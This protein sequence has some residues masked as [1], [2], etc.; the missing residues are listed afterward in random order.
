MSISLTYR[1]PAFGRAWEEEKAEAFALSAAGEIEII[2]ADG[3]REAGGGLSPAGEWWVAA[4]RRTEPRFFEN[5]G[6][7]FEL[8]LGPAAVPVIQGALIGSGVGD[9]L[10]LSETFDDRLLAIASDGYWH[11]PD[12]VMA[13]EIVICPQDFPLPLL[14]AP[15]ARERLSILAA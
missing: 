5:G 14:E 11:F 4:E 10:T 9:R 13:P 2:R 3:S 1:P 15:G 7:P 6:D 12:D 8:R